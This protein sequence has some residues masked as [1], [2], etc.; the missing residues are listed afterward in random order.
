VGHDLQEPL[1]KKKDRK[2]KKR[3]IGK[4]KEGSMG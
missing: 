1:G 2:E 4:R 3:R